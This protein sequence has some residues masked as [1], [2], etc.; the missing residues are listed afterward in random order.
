ME[1]TE[2]I[3][4]LLVEDNPGD[5][6]LVRRT[7]EERGLPGEL[8]VVT[9]GDEALDWLHGRDEYADAPRPDVVLLDLNLPSVDGLTVLEEVTDDERLRRTPVVVFTG[10]QSEADLRRA[11]ER[12]A[13]ACLVKP[14]DPEAFADAVE[15]FAS[16][17][18][19]T[20]TLPGRSPPAGRR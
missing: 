4:V 10:A 9:R 19:D 7:F 20:A 18:V 3:D 15:S 6:H 8:H 13:N 5:A 1:S 17:W 12:G 2:T 16:F 14:V 11:Y